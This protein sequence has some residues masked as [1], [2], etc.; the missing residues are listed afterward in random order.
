MN[1]TLIDN[2]IKQ[3]SE[4]NSGSPWIDET[5]KKKIDALTDAEAFAKP[6]PQIHSVAELISH[7]TEWRK[8]IADAL[9]GLP[10]ESIFDTPSNWKSNDL[11]K[12][13]GWNKLKN[14]FYDSH[15]EIIFFLEKQNDA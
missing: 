10:Y 8:I 15:K 5:F 7:L 12:P 6:L 2:Y 1:R 9:T 11:L 13:L 4:I 14:E 3:F